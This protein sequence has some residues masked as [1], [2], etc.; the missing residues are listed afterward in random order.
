M[1]ARTF[2]ENTE[3]VQRQSHVLG[4]RVQWAESSD[5]GSLGWGKESH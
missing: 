2:G 3:C 1:E 4:S 5:L